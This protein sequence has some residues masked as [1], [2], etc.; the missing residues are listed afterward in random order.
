MMQA[1]RIASLICALLVPTD[2][3]CVT[4]IPADSIADAMGMNIHIEDFG[5]SYDTN[6][7]SWVT[8]LNF[9]GVRYV[10]DGAR[11]P[12]GDSPAHQQMFYDR[13]KFIG[14]TGIKFLV[15]TPDNY[16]FTA[17]AEFDLTSGGNSWMSLRGPNEPPASQAYSVRMYQQNL[18]KFV[19]ADPLPSPSGA[20]VEVGGPALTA[21]TTSWTAFGD[22]TTMSQ[23]GDIHPYASNA[24]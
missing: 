10:R 15:P 3:Q 6:W 8:Q 22:L 20:N 7:P 4:P 14:S 13:E 11:A 16:N 17:N 5:R 19:L 2:G 18:Y 23:T 1:A 21:P 24:P 9:A 12:S